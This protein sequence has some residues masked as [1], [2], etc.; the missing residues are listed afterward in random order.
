[1]KNLRN[2]SPD[3]AKHN[4]TPDRRQSKRF[5]L[6]RILGARIVVQERSEPAFGGRDVPIL[7][8]GIVLDLVALDFADAEIAA[9]GMGVVKAADR[10]TRPHRKTL[11]QLHADL[12]L[13]IEQL[14]Q[15]RLLAVLGLG[16]IAG[17]R[18]DAAIFFLDQ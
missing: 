3:S 5:S 10:G 18:A 16:G 9:L 14:E 17:C 7:A 6:R 11:G 4:S 15:R 8:L 12:R 2:P 1:M 13:R